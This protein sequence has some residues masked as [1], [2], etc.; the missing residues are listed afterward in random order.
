VGGAPPIDRAIGIVLERR[1]LLRLSGE[2]VQQL[3]ALRTDIQEENT[4]LRDQMQ[5]LREEVARDRGTVRE[6]MEDFRA[7]ARELRDGQQG[8]L[9]D[10]LSQD[11]RDRL[12]E[13]MWRSR[14]ARLDDRGRGA[15]GRGF[16][17]GAGLFGGGGPEMRA[18]LQG[19]RDGL[20]PGA[21]FRG[22]RGRA[23]LGPGR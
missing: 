21:R 20:R 22:G 10:I 3:E 7:K 14:P 11:Q 2:Q 4:D 18:Y 19:L 16:R 8:R 6:R 9:E 23:A 17:S 12:G 1:D 13:I 5:E 15:R